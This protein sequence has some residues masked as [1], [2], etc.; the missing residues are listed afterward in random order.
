MTEINGTVNFEKHIYSSMGSDD[1][2]LI[3]KFP[4]STHGDVILKHKIGNLSYEYSY[5]YAVVWRKA[6]K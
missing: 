3:I 2:V 1:K 5:I 6:R 4:S